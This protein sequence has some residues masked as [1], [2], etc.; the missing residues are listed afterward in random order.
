[1]GNNSVT[2]GKSRFAARIFIAL[3]AVC[4]ALTAIPFLTPEALPTAKAASVTLLG[5]NKDEINTAISE[6]VDNNYFI[7]GPKLMKF[8]EN[9]AKYIGT[10]YCVGVGNGFDGLTL[11][12]RAMGVNSGGEVI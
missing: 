8:E 1:M 10:K 3:M 11:S 4:L 5:R 7:Q 2:K 9:F 12:L 6:V